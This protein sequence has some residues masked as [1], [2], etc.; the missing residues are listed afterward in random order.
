MVS[1][2]VPALAGILPSLASQT[3]WIFDLW[4]N[5]VNRATPSSSWKT[6]R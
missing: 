5:R 1:P 6:P 3:S 4:P 2:I